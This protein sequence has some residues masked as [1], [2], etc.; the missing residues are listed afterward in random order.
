MRAASIIAIVAASL[1]AQGL[2]AQE[3]GTISRETTA[4]PK[5]EKKVCRRTPTTGSRLVGASVCHS[6]SEW[7]QID[8]ATAADID[9]ARH[10][11]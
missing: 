3:A 7:A 9:R 1:C 10:R 11:N 4:E 2:V 8:A 5:K 6:E